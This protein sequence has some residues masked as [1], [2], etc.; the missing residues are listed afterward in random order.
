MWSAWGDENMHKLLVG[1]P[2][3]RLGVDGKKILKW[4]FLAS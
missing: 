4:N 1:K 3:E 2:E